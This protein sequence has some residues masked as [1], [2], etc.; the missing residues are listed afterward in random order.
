MP[1]ILRPPDRITARTDHPLSK[2]AHCSRRSLPEYI[3]QVIVTSISR[4]PFMMNELEFESLLRRSESETIDFKASGYDLSTDHGK[5]SLVK[6]VISLA[7]TPRD[8]ESFIVV[9][10]KKNADS[11]YELRGCS[12]HADEADLQSQFVERV[13]PIPRF[14]YEIV[15]YKGKDFGLFRVPCVRVGPCV[16]LR[17]YGD[18]LRRVQVYFRRG[19]KNDVATPEDT[20]RILSWLGRHVTPSSAY[21]HSD[22]AWEVFLREVHHFDPARHYFLVATRLPPRSND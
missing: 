11:T 8:E 4:K 21:A 18:A 10:V 9:G 2:A 17:D 3:Q 13:Y 12:A 5:F 22:P 19:S 16:P 7:N 14:V 20:L 1:H 6:D 15:P